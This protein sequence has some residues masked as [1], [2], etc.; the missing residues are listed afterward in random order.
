LV[1]DKYTKLSVYGHKKHP[2]KSRTIKIETAS[3]YLILYRISTQNEK[4]VTEMF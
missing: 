1:T 2:P 3:S 4:Y